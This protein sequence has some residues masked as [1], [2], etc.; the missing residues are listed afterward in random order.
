MKRLQ[1]NEILPAGTRVHIASGKGYYGVVTGHTPAPCSCT[2]PVHQ[3]KI[4]Q[5]YRRLPANRGGYVEVEPWEWAG[6]YRFVSV[7]DNY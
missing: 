2:C 6:S 7:F 5:E 1:A 3:I 4:E